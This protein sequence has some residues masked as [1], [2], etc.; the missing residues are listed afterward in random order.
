V[1]AELVAAATA[2]LGRV[3]ARISLMRGSRPTVAESNW[4]SAYLD[5]GVGMVV[6]GFGG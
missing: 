1:K 4:F 3:S 6:Y 5:G 2:S